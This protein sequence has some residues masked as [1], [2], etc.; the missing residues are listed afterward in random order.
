M[1]GEGL[2]VIDGCLYR[3]EG[4]TGG[5]IRNKS[6][7]A[8]GSGITGINAVTAEGIADAMSLKNAHVG[9]CMGKSGCE[10]AKDASDIII[11]DDNQPTTM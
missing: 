10:A 3:T 1:T 2:R 7:S 11:L 9:F 6:C 8:D 4:F 5:G